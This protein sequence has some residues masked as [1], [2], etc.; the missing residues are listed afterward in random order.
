[1]KG[2]VVALVVAVAFASAG[3][4]AETSFDCGKASSRIEQ[5]VCKNVSLNHLD[6][7]LAS[8]YAGAL[9][10]TL[11]K[12]GIVAK[13]RAWLRQRD[14]C[15]DEK[16]LAAKYQQQIAFLSD[17]SEDPAIC[18]S[19]AT[20]DVNACGQ[21][22]AR[23]AQSELDRY[24]DAAR[25]RISEDTVASEGEGD[26]KQT[27]A[28]FDT[29]ERAWEAYRKAECEAV[30]DDWSGG[31]IRGAMYEGCWL[32]E[33]KARTESVWEDWLQSEDST[34]PVLPKPTDN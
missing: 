10:R 20:I 12:D 1:M 3:R 8:A 7:Q 16:C 34:P 11:H 13:Q 23:R 18:A 25:K 26:T 2:I 5:M 9:D 32:T 17:V 28:A 30:Y 29:A 33:T 19:P 24:L 21:E 14:D 15:T 31:T 22:H 4:A 27:R 6:S